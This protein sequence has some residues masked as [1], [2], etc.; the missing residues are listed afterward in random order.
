M[1]DRYLQ[2][3]RLP[4]QHKRIR[5]RNSIFGYQ[6]MFGFANVVRGNKAFL[7]ALNYDVGPLDSLF[8]PPPL[9]SSARF[10]R[11]HNSMLESGVR[12]IMLFNYAARK[13]KL[14]IF[15]S[16]FFEFSANPL[17]PVPEAV[18]EER[19]RRGCRLI[20]SHLIIYHFSFSQRTQLFL[21]LCEHNKATMNE[22][23]FCPPLRPPSQSRR[24][25]GEI[26]SHKRCVAEDFRSIVR[27]GSRRRRFTH[28][29]CIRNESLGR[30]PNPFGASL[31]PP[32]SDENKRRVKVGWDWNQHNERKDG[33]Q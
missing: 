14:E 7:S 3:T 1:I 13:S 2:R 32:S 16:A 6:S 12:P 33:K 24:G 23:S 30:I 5:V 8:S 21:S 29:A 27:R 9:S 15:L 22:L 19:A 28:R 11:N 31:S 26:F 10:E 20:N 17:R 4:Y 18:E 25:E